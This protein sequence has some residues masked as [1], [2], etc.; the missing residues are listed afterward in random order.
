MWTDVVSLAP[1]LTKVSNAGQGTIL[2]YV[3]T[4][5]DVC[6]FGKLG[7]DSPKLKLAR[8]YL[9]AHL[10]SLGPHEGIL[11]SEKEDDLEM[12]WTLPPIPPFGD[13]FWYRTAYGSAYDA[14]IRT[15]TARLPF[16]VGMRR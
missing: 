10:G 15:T 1:E 5:L 3:N 11:T 6:Q 2:A 16:V 8:I 14:L 9:A 4:A 7:E 13:P 12:G